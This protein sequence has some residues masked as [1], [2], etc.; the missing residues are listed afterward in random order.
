M[1]DAPAPVPNDDGEKCYSVLSFTPIPYLFQA[2]G[3]YFHFMSSVTFLRSTHSCETTE[4][5]K[6]R[7]SKTE[8]VVFQNTCI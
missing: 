4:L 3:A 1:G 8:S 7:F 2:W 6:A 5:V